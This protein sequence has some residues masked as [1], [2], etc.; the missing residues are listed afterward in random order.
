MNEK[1]VSD[2]RDDR[3]RRP[4]PRRPRLAART[5]PSSWRGT[6][7]TRRAPRPRWR[8]RCPLAGL[9]AWKLYLGLPL[10][11]SRAP[12]G[13]IDEVM[14][15]G[16]E[17]AV[18]NLH[19][20][21]HE[22]AVAEFPAAFAELRERFGIADDAP[23]GLL[24]GSAGSSIAAGVLAGGESGATAAVLVS[25]MLRLR[26][27]V[28]VLSEFFGVDYKWSAESDRAAE[29][30]DFVARAPEVIAT[31][32]AIRVIAGRRRQRGRARAGARVRR[33]DRRRSARPRR[34]RA[35]ARRGAGRRRRTADR[36][37]EAGRRARRGVVPQRARLTR[38]ATRAAGRG[39]STGTPAAPRDR[40]AGTPGAPA[41]SAAAGAGGCGI[42]CVGGNAGGCAGSG[43]RDRRHRRAAARVG[44][45]ERLGRR[46]S[47][48]SGRHGSRLDRRHGRSGGSGSTGGDRRLGGRV[49]RRRGAARAA[50]GAGGP[51]GGAAGRAPCGADAAASAAAIDGG[52]PGRGR[53]LRLPRPLP[54]GAAL[55][56]P[57]LVAPLLRALDDPVQRRQHDQGEQGRRHQ[58]ADHD[59]RQR[60]RDEPAVA[61][62]A[63]RHRRQRADRRERRHQDRPQAS[64]GP[65][66]DRLAHVHPAL[67]VLVHQVDEHDRVRHHDADQHQQPDD[68][69]A[70]RA[71]CR[72]R[73]AAAPRRSPRTGSRPAAAAAAAGSG[74]S[75]P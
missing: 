14:R 47:G 19:W 43:R 30:M 60:L 46:R 39:S 74:T 9:D 66:D 12:E 73:A 52:H 71:G 6:C 28:D 61:G 75:R 16:M 1:S 53:A 38:S 69:R 34:D 54:R 68:R 40:A 22:Q 11:G 26:S 63:D 33:G 13:G 72:R 45:R 10:S 37:G 42:G 5:R 41:A 36:G 29:R 8:R 49:G 48:G 17:D 44:R 57:A 67:A 7:S 50:A 21:I 27:M 59:D 23:I 51:A 56:G 25:P 31:G 15:L 18:L 62:D 65:V 35:P 58:A 20:P 70:R 32:A 2:H 4:L 3:E 24:G 64:G 55:G